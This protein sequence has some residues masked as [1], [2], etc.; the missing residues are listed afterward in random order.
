MSQ[1]LNTIYGASLDNGRI[2][3]STNAI[4]NTIPLEMCLLLTFQFLCLSALFMEQA[5]V[6]I[7]IFFYKSKTFLLTLVLI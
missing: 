2:G 4:E 3:V 5:T 1:V 6:P 7:A